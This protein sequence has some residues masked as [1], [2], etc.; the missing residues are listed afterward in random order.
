MKKSVYILSL[1]IF[2]IVRPLI[3][4]TDNQELATMYRNDQAARQKP[5]IDWETLSREDDAREKRVY[6]LLASSKV[7]TGR[8]H[9]HAAMIFQHGSDTT[10][11]RMAVKMMRKAIELDSTINKWLLAAA[12][13]RDL[14]RRN[15][16]QIYGT[17]FI[18][19]HDEKQWRRY[20][21]DSTKVTDEERK[22]YGVETLAEQRAKERRMNML[23]LY[24]F[25]STEKSISKVIQQIK[26]EAEKGDRAR[27]NVSEEGV[28]SF[29]Y[30]L[31]AEGKLNDALEIFQLNTQLYPQGYNTWD[32]LGECLMALNRKEESVKAYKKSLELNPK[33]ENA[34]KIVN[35]Q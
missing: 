11:S 31:M 15:Q 3:A 22:A 1:L 12:I 32:S 35:G 16:P 9:Y 2:C 23:R 34:R 29:G 20:K 30:E 5:N 14:M 19:M 13:D 28:N 4:Q 8:D 27:Y 6:E 25:Y 18:K 24:D 21:I 26:A 17:Q 33:N 10:A 7:I